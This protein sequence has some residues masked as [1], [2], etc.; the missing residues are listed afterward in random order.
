[1]NAN[2]IIYVGQLILYN[3]LFMLNYFYL[4]AFTLIT[5]IIFFI[6]ASF[7]LFIV[8]KNAIAPWEP[9]TLLCSPYSKYALIYECVLIFTLTLWSVWLMFFIISEEGAWVD[10]VIFSFEVLI[11]A[12]VCV[13]LVHL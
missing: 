8:T 6:M 9:E 7:I 11:I 2:T 12:I 4:D 3:I 10:S 13:A 1:M 5:R